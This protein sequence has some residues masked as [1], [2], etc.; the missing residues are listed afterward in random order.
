[1]DPSGFEKPILAFTGLIPFGW[2]TQG[3]VIWNVSGGC[4]PGFNMNWFASAPD[5]S[6][7][8]AM[9]AG[10]GWSYNNM[11]PAGPQPGCLP[12]RFTTV[13]EYLEYL[14]Q[15]GRSGARVLDY[16]V[17]PDLLKGFEQLNQVT[18]M[19]GGGEMRSWSEAGEVLIAYQL[20]GIDMRETVNSVVLFSS[21]RFPDLNGGM[22][23]HFAA[24]A[25]PGFAFRAPAGQLDFKLA[26]AIRSSIRS[27][28]DWQSR[29]NKGNEAVNKT[30]ISTFDPNLIAREGAKRSEIIA[31]T[32][33][34]IREMQRQST[35][36]YNSIT[37]SIQSSNVETIRG[38][39][40]YNDPQSTTGT[41]ELS[42]QYSQAWRLQDGSY[43][44]TDDPSFNPYLA[45]GQD[46]AK[47]EP[48][49]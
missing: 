35:D 36:T 49:P 42:N 19:S 25:L 21:T 14:V 45:T 39:E 15:T 18:P 4:S 27:V 20:G 13:R 34:Q 7:G 40:T 47:L 17:R 48:T 29:V 8:A 38:V 26:E 10:T 2:Q 28:P 33:D 30:V 23:E 41:V 24:N 6:S 43:V 22:L 11:A 37:S 16:R 31:Q 44:L 9:F 3:G 5:G 46:G 32:G 12:V 1:M